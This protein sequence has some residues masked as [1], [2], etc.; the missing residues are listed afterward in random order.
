MMF[1]RSF[2]AIFAILFFGAGPALA[3][4]TKPHRLAL[5]ISDD[6]P[7][8]MN[9]VLSVAANVSRYYSGQ[10]EEVEIEIIA[11][12][13]GLHMLRPDTSPVAKRI[14]SFAQSMTNVKFMACGNTMKGMA[15]KE[16]KLPPI[17]K[18]AKVV[19]AGV[20][21]LMERDQAGWTII[22]P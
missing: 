21:S 16:G 20:I 15:K 8:K 9:T 5:Q 4:G 10:G 12:N 14:T 22:R 19:P 7:Q 1:R 11:F 3:D 6:S 2:L 18:F 13:K 17:Y